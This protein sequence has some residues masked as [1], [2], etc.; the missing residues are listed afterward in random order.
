MRT[1]RDGDIEIILS[2]G[3]TLQSLER[4]MES[5]GEGGVEDELG[6]SVAQVLANVAEAVAVGIINLDDT[7]V[8]IILRWMLRH[9]R[10][11]VVVVAGDRRT[12]E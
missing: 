10:R 11:V 8:G 7:S 2:S 1:N 9:R 4:N 12:Y 5:I 6:S 3:A